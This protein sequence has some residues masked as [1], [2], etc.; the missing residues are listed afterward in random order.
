MFNDGGEI[1]A[2]MKNAKK[3][4]KV[5]ERKRI[6]NRDYEASM[7]TAMKKVEKAV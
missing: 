1:M 3:A 6:E 2:N 4:I 7:K 5:I